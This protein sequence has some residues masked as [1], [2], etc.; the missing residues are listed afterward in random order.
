MAAFPEIFATWSV[1]KRGKINSAFTSVIG[2]NAV[3]LTVAYFPLAMVNLTVNNFPFFAT[4]LNFVGL[5]GI[6]DDAFI[7]GEEKK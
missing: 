7:L 3:T 5:V 1:A 6:L 2:G 4:V